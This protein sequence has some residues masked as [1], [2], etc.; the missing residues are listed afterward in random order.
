MGKNIEVEIRTF[1]SQKKYYELVKFFKKEGKFLAQEKQ[2]TYYFDCPQD[3]RIQ[4]SSSYAKVWLKSGQIHDDQR[5]EIEVKADRNKFNDLKKLFLTL[6]Y[7]VEIAWDRTRNNFRWQGCDI[8]VDFTKGYGYIL[9]IEKLATPKDKDKALNKINKLMQKLSLEITPK[10]EFKT[11][12]EWY[13]KNWHKFVKI[14]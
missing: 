13:K 12:F 4:Q 9:E 5:Q 14:K 1:I 2:L 7:K 10:E 8:A 11:K 3:L 6:G